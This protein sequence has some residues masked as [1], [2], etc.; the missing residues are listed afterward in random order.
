MTI[1]HY[2]VVKWTQR[3][4][5]VLDDETLM[6]R[7]DDRPLYEVESVNHDK[8]RLD[9]V[10]DRCEQGWLRVPRSGKIADR[11]ADLGRRLRRM[12]S[13]KKRRGRRR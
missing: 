3:D 5:F 6:I 9:D 12:L 10:P 13:T 11:D 4:G 1:E 8:H 7:F 2:F